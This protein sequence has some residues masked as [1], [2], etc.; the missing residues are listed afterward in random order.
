MVCKK[1]RL[2]V[3]AV[4]PNQSRAAAAYAGRECVKDY[5]I[6]FFLPRK[7]FRNFHKIGYLSNVSLDNCLTSDLEIN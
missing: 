6:R 5:K 3:A 4:Q 1:G 2:I 7:V